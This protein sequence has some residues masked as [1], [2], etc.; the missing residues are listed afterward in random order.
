MMKF[1]SA[2]AGIC[3][4][5]LAACNQTKG[6]ATASG[7]EMGQSANLRSVIGQY[8]QQAG[9]PKEMRITAFW[10]VVLDVLIVVASDC[11]GALAGAKA[12]READG[13]SDVGASVGAIGG[14]ISASVAA[15]KALDLVAPGSPSPFNDPYSPYGG[16]KPATLDT[17]GW[18]HNDGVQYAVINGVALSSSEVYNSAVALMA[19]AHDWPAS[20]PVSAAI[21]DSVTT[22]I[23]TSTTTAGM[24][25]AASAQGL[26]TE[27]GYI[28]D[29]IADLNWLASNG[30]PAA[31]AFSLV[32]TYSSG[33]DTDSSLSALTSA[34][35]KNLKYSL[36]VFKYSLALWVENP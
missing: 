25:T 21:I 20:W 22:P 32:D 12:G 9:G 26:T 11:F 8:K 31:A 17:I 4:I 13:G 10:D 7:W 28:D 33:V 36:S 18:L 23:H 35:K 14:A 6:P 5:A 34:Q 2:A 19:T 16:S 29:L 27:A 30:Y 24:S 15:G 1:R 3:L